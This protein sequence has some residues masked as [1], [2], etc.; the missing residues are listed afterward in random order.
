MPMML[1][2]NGIRRAYNQEIVDIINPSI[3]AENRIEA[4]NQAAHFSASQQVIHVHLFSL[5]NK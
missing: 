4:E 3:K 2:S 1:K 5:C